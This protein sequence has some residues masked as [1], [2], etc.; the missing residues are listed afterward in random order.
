MQILDFFKIKLSTQAS[1]VG[2]AEEL[3]GY[4]REILRALC[5]EQKRQF[6]ALE[7]KADGP[8]VD[9][10]GEF[11]AL[12]FFSSSKVFYLHLKTDPQ[13]WTDEAK[14]VWE[15]LVQ[16]SSPQGNWLFV[17]S[18]SEK[19]LGTPSLKIL[20][21]SAC[22]HSYA[23]ATYFNET[24]N[25]QL[26]TEKINFL[27]TQEIEDILQLK[28]WIELWT[29]GG[30]EWARHALGWGDSSAV[31]TRVFQGDRNLSYEWVDAALSG[32]KRVFLQL[33]QQLIEK[34]GEDPIRLLA[35][36]GKSVKI[37]SQLSLNEEVVGEPPFLITKMKKLK[38][39][40]ELLEWWCKCDL[41]LKSTR[42]DALGLLAQM[43]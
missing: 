8:G 11:S 17:S 2:L 1:W 32:N 29:L 19:F 21:G 16:L 35:L 23:W 37:S 4:E 22:A 31:G 25:A 12:D 13:K 7:I 33:S 40:P 27:L 26:N 24:L 9:L 18:E 43:P 6:V 39:R 15:R 20:N 3:T 41:S 42:A 10:E 34:E 30:D 28:H 38:F 14:R 36:L 5:S